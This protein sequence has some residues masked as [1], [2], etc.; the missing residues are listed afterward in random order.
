MPVGN[1]TCVAQWTVNQYTVTFNANG[2]TG[3]LVVTKD[4][5]A[6]LVAPVVTREGYVFAGWSPAVPATVPAAN[7]TY[8]AQWTPTTCKVVFSANGGKGKMAAQAFTYGKAAALRKNAFTRSGYVFIGWAKSKGGAVAYANGATVKNPAAAGKTI[9]LYAKW[10]KKNYKVAF[11]ANGG[12]G[13]MAAQTMTYGK[14]KKLP[15]NKFKAPKGKKFA[16][17]ATSRANAKKGK[18]KYK[19]KAAVKNLVAN[20]KTVKLYAVW[21]KK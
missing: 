9:T 1:T 11:Y 3:G 19:N 2:G 7:A 12:T 10:A 8:V 20:G 16:G 17:W 14:A 15:A 5:G 18:V 13:K 6:V 21:K 4:Y